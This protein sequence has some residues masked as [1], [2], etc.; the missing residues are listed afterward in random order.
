MAEEEVQ[1]L[2]ND[3]NLMTG[4]VSVVTK[5]GRKLAFNVKEVDLLGLSSKELV[6]GRQV[7]IRHNYR[8][9]VALV[10]LLRS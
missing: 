6:K 9:A 2:V 8:G 7:G 3:V 4:Q 5:D 10:S 1:A